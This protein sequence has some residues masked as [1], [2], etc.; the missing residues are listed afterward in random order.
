MKLPLFTDIVVYVKQ[1]YSNSFARQKKMI[2]NQIKPDIWTYILVIPKT[3]LPPAL[4]RRRDNHS[5]ALDLTHNPST[6]ITAA[7]FEDSR[8]EA[9][10]T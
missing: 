10:K 4:L 8:I 3:L 7:S 2:T 9:Q 6:V 5:A 1:L